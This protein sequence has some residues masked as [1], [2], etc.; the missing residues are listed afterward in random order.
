MS[1][2]VKTWQISILEESCT[3]SLTGALMCFVDISVSGAIK[4]SEAERNSHIRLRAW[5]SCRA[6]AACLR[7]D[8]CWAALGV[9]SIFKSITTHAKFSGRKQFGKLSYH[10]WT[11]ELKLS[12]ISDVNSIHIWSFCL[13]VEATNQFPLNAMI[14]GSDSSSKG[15]AWVIHILIVN[16]YTDRDERS[17]TAETLC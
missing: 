17:S 15:R 10:A 4:T 2:H 12:V 8:G 9:Q 11:T 14:W 7:P 16:K 13:T 3:H 5:R 1:R 6:I